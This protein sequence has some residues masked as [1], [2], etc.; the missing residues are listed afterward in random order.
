MFHV[1]RRTATDMM[2]PIVTLSNF[3]NAP[4]NMPITYHLL[5]FSNYTHTVLKGPMAIAEESYE[6]YTEYA[7][8]HSPTLTFYQ[9]VHVGYYEVGN[10]SSYPS[11]R[12]EIIITEYVVQPTNAQIQFII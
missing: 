5:M 10:T 3:T 7:L 1:G 12:E 4:K 8:Q 6:L 11:N 2:E 9:M